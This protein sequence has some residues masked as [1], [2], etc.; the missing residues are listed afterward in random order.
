M[1][2]VPGT[3]QGTIYIRPTILLQHAQSITSYAAS[4]ELTANMTAATDPAV[5]LYQTLN[6]S[7]IHGRFAEGQQS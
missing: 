3:I 2:R 4:G 1:L 6:I 7:C 5:Q